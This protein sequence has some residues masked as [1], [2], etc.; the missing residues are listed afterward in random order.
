[1]VSSGLKG[2]AIL[3]FSVLVGFELVGFLGQSLLDSALVHFVDILSKQRQAWYFGWVHLF[4]L[5][6][7]CWV[8]LKE[9]GLWMGCF[10]GC[11]H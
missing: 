11:F 8:D 4:V 6:V 2:D 5:K 10:F 7:F 9:L 3:F 1:M